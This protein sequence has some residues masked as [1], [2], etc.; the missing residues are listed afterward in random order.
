MSLCSC[1]PEKEYDLECFSHG[2]TN[3]LRLRIK[4]LEEN[5]GMALEGI[6]QAARDIEFGTSS[7]YDVVKQLICLS[8]K[9]RG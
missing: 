9:L 8:N 5:M 7:L 2:A 1:D 4:N 6:D 3:K